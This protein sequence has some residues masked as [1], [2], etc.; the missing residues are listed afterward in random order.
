MLYLAQEV[1]EM[2]KRKKYLLNPKTTTLHING[3]CCYTE[4]NYTEWQQF[5]TE[6]EVYRLLGRA[7]KMCKVCARKRDEK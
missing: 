6:E 4:G 3:A 2:S 7:F 1:S 5:D